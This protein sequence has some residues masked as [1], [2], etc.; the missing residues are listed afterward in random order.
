MCIGTTIMTCKPLSFGIAN[1][2]QN[3]VCCNCFRVFPKLSACA[4]CNYAHYC[5]RQCQVTDWYR[6]LR[7]V[8][9]T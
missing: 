2:K 4:K 7:L 9:K 8:S 1:D 5:C 6:S 3:N